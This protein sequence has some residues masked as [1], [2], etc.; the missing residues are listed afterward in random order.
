M[1]W[2]QVAS[3]T[4][5]YVMRATIGNTPTMPRSVD[6]KYLEYLAGATDNDF[7]V[8][9]YHRAHVGRA[10]GDAQGEADYFVN[11]AQIEGGDVLPVLD[12]EQT[13]G[14]DPAEM[15][16]WVKTWVLRVRA[17]TGVRPMLYSSPNFWNVHMGGTTWF[18]DH[19]YPLWIAHWGSRQPAVPA[20]NWSGRGWTFWQWTSTGTVAGIDTDVDRDRFNGMNLQHGR[21]ASLTVTPP[22][23]G[24]ISGP[25]ISCGGTAATCSRLANPDTVV[26]LTA[27]P[28][29]DA[30]LMGWTACAAAGAA[31]TCDVTL[32]GA[33][34]VSAVF[35]F[36][37]EIERRGSGAGTVTSSRPGSRAERCAPRRSLPGARSISPRHR[38]RRPRSRAGAAVARG[39]IPSARS[40]CRVR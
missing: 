9:A 26:T 1:D 17:R 16:D 23:V 28:D 2:A 32:L 3:T 30:T 6:P 10:D 40:R 27:T 22:V 21:V 20:G 25:R 5:K 12:I 39:S 35:G 8:G 13:H 36:P 18:A 19:D 34:T 38:T 7:V 15:E 29:Q 11:H 37:V 14:L 24:T 33:K 31:P 4:T